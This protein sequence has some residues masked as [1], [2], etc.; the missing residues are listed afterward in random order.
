MKTES[1]IEIYEINGTE[2]KPVERPV[3]IV[4]NHWNR[5]NFVVIEIDDKN[6]TVEAGELNRAIE[7]AKNAHKF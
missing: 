4:R 6:Y 1:K 2:S 5:R 3:I 7:N